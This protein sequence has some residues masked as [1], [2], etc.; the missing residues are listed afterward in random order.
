M[1]WAISASPVVDQL[2]LDFATTLIAAESLGE[3]AVPDFLA[4]SFSGVDAVNHFF[5]PSSLEQ[6]ALMRELDSTL[7][8]P[9]RSKPSSVLATAQPPLTSPTTWSIGQRASVK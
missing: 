2:T 3:D 4:I 9:P 7:A 8:R 6:E 1:D 5:G